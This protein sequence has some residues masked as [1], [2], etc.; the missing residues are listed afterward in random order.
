MRIIITILSLA[1]VAAIAAKPACTV[2]VNR[3]SVDS[4][5]LCLPGVGKS[6]ANRIDSA[7]KT[8]P[9]SS[10]ADLDAVKGFGEKKLAKVCPLVVF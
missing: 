2:N 7:R 1:T 5:A 8:K 4:L 9:F 6:T 10:C 3:S